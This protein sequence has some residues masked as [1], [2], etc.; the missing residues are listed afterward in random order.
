MVS[1]EKTQ[2]YVRFSRI[3]PRSKKRKLCLSTKTIISI[4]QIHGT[5]EKCQTNLFSSWTTEKA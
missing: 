5:P 1:N 2:R 3:I 4:P